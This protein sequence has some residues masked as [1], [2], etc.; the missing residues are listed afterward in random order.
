MKC[1]HS[2]MF[3]IS[4][5]NIRDQD[6]A[7]PPNSNHHP[8]GRM[9]MG[10]VVPVSAR[11][12]SHASFGSHKLLREAPPCAVFPHALEIMDTCFMVSLNGLCLVA[13]VGECSATQRGFPEL[14]GVSCAIFRSCALMSDRN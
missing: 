8:R 5:L 3:I 2:S 13:A 6:L 12:P 11:S 1:K 14:L 10:H 4:N 7:N 9:G